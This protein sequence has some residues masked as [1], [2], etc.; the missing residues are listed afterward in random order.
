MADSISRMERREGGVLNADLDFSE[1]DNQATWGEVRASLINPY[2]FAKMYRAALRKLA[3]SIP[4]SLDPK[5]ADAIKFRKIVKLKY[6]TGRLITHEANNELILVVAHNRSVG[7]SR[8]ALQSLLMHAF[9]LYSWAKV[10]SAT[11]APDSVG[12]RIKFQA[13]AS[14]MLSGP[15]KEMFQKRI[16]ILDDIDQKRIIELNNQIADANSE[17]AAIKARQE[18]RVADETKRLIEFIEFIEK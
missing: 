1:Y 6:G 2:E 5:A 18:R 12:I 10:E 8:A 4:S 14:K 16:K 13:D 15:L 3:K 7:M 11:C 9:S 17:L